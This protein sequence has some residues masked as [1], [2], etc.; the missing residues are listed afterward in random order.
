MWNHLVTLSIDGREG[1]EAGSEG[2]IA[3]EVNIER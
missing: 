2:K 3:K 1:M